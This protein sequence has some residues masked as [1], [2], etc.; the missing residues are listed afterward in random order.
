MFF[1]LIQPLQGAY[2]NLMDPYF[3]GENLVLPGYVQEKIKKQLDNGAV[4]EN[5]RIDITW[6]DQRGNTMLYPVLSRG[7][8][9]LSGAGGMS[10]FLVCDM[11]LNPF[12]ENKSGDTA[13][14]V[15]LHKLRKKAEAGKFKGKEGAVLLGSL[16]DDY[17]YLFDIL[18]GDNE[19]G[20]LK[21]LGSS[22]RMFLDFLHWYKDKMD[23]EAK[24]TKIYC[25]ETEGDKTT[26]ES[27]FVVSMEKLSLY[28]DIVSD[29]IL[30]ERVK[31]VAK[32]APKNI[33]FIFN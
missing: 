10:S 23:S 12:I 8:Y 18:I 7:S 33:E 20:N 28:I 5:G 2:E 25:L 22:V 26:L 17:M 29:K 31:V 27:A 4:N 15:A 24:K 11:K 21:K 1:G 14:D 9:K 3:V 19:C 30:K 16:I 32:N 6:R 13:I